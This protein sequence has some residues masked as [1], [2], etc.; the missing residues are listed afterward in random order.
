MTE[1]E[2]QTPGWAT[3]GARVGGIIGAAVGLLVYV[4]PRMMRPLDEAAASGPEIVLTALL[5]AAGG[6]LP[7]AAVGAAVAAAFGA[8]FEAFVSRPPNREPPD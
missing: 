7:C 3:D 4:L 5:H 6:G 8:L 2:Q 1:P